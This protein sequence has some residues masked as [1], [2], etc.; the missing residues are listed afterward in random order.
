LAESHG[1]SVLCY[2]Q[3]NDKYNTF[4]N[5]ILNCCDPTHGSKIKRQAIN[6]FKTIISNTN[7]D[8]Q[9]FLECSNDIVSRCHEL[10]HDS[11]MGVRKEAVTL[12][13]ELLM[14]NC[15]TST[16]TNTDWMKTVWKN[17]VS[18]LD[19]DSTQSTVMRAINR[20][21][22][23]TA[24]PA[25]IGFTKDVCAKLLDK[26]Q[27]LF[28]HS[29][30]S[31]KI[32][33]LSCVGELVDTQK[34]IQ[35][36]ENILINACNVI[37]N[38]QDPYL[39]GM[40]LN[41]IT[42]LLPN[43]VDN[44]SKI[45]I[46]FF[47]EWNKKNLKKN[48]VNI[49]SSD[50]LAGTEALEQFC[51]FLKKISKMDSAKNTN[52][53]INDVITDSVSYASISKNTMGAVSKCIRSLCFSSTDCLKAT[54]DYFSQMILNGVKPNTSSTSNTG[55][56]KSGEFNNDNKKLRMA[57]YGLGEISEESS[58]DI[59]Q[60]LNTKVVDE[61]LNNFDS[62]DGDI[63][64]ACAHCLGSACTSNMFEYLP[65]VCALGNT[66][67]KLKG[68]KT[69]SLAGRSSTTAL[70]CMKHMM[71]VVN[72]KAKTSEASTRS[73]V[74]EID[75]SP[76]V[77]SILDILR[78]I[79]FSETP[80]SDHEILLASECWGLVST[81]PGV[82][83]GVLKENWIAYYVASKKAFAY[84]NTKTNETSWDRPSK[85]VN[86]NVKFITE[87]INIIKSTDSKHI[88][89]CNAVNALSNVV[90]SLGIQANQEIIEDSEDLRTAS[91]IAG[92]NTSESAPGALRQLLDG[93]LENIV[94]FANNASGEI[95]GNALKTGEAALKL[96]G[97]LL[98]F[99]KPLLMS[100]LYVDI[101][102]MLLTR[103]KTH[104]EEEI[105]M[106]AFK[107]KIDHAGPMR[108]AAYHCMIPILYALGSKMKL[109]PQLTEILCAGV[110]KPD[111][112]NNGKPK[113]L[114]TGRIMM[115]YNGVKDYDPEIRKLSYQMLT[116]LCNNVPLQLIPQMDNLCYG[117]LMT[118]LNV[119]LKKTKI[120]E[121]SGDSK[122]D[123]TIVLAVKLSLAINNMQ[124][125]NAIFEEYKKK[126][127]S[128]KQ[129]TLKQLW[130]QLE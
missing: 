45:F 108:I 85:P 61:I 64:E 26:L 44:K 74:T 55:E 100:R 127:F 81:L 79:L 68:L 16:A 38:S 110:F 46:A 2:A 37:R 97:A 70:L 3:D 103:M 69:S 9:M 47:N 28:K 117:M 89:Q 56:T 111:E 29:S 36:S 22:A 130:D 31:I 13:A 5:G 116:F 107:M 19:N 23:S 112:K 6:L 123:E 30:H 48:V 33:A 10:V 1:N 91:E 106:G 15:T 98:S 120:V 54:I 92:S 11:D 125:D 82:G 113:K 122:N 114:K 78:S 40:A 49:I 20:V 102:P 50:N 12:Y 86:H 126:W 93:V 124:G 8:A 71:M 39:A 51:T 119:G 84:N 105:D 35:N 27:N 52:T 83:Y 57:L 72:D 121:L 21:F 18:M 95:R 104:M 76:H 129:K 96:I 41:C 25:S 66:S 43:E 101:L 17:L 80:F 14:F 7:D 73:P 118:D 128:D 109:I 115:D 34:D 87:L 67:S 42:S 88:H 90:K 63:R 24:S 4:I 60:N 94:N 62:K 58:I 99:H 75:M 32:N 65:K 77:I 59:H 53:L